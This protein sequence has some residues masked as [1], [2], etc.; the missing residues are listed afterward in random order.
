MRASASKAQYIAI[1]RR[2][3]LLVT[4]G[5]RPLICKRTS[6]SML[7]PF[8]LSYELVNEILKRDIELIETAK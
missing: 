6:P 3:P 7:L 5:D 4:I 2:R 1:R 8:P